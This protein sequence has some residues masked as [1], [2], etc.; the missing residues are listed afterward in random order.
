MAVGITYLA[1]STRT[2][3]CRAECLECRYIY[4]DFSY[5]DFSYCYYRVVAVAHIESESER[6]FRVGNVV[7]RFPFSAFRFAHGGAYALRGLF[8]S[9]SSCGGLHFPLRMA[10]KFVTA[11]RVFCEPTNK[12]IYLHTY[13]TKYTL[14]THTH[15]HT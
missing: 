9:S 12:F 13:F 14:G 7:A 5:I 3:R 15:T 2:V 1:R 6:E 11:T 4:I 8:C 10:T